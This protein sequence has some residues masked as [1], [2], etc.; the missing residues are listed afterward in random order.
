MIMK[1]EITLFCLIGMLM[2]MAMRTEAQVG[3]NNDN[4]PVDRSAGLDVKFTD[5]GVLIPRLTF[6]QRNA[7]QN[8]AEGLMVYCTNCKRDGTGVIS[9][10]QGGLWMNVTDCLEPDRPAAGIHQVDVAQITWIWEPVPGA[11][12]YKWSTT[13]DFHTASDMGSNTSMSETGLT[14]GITYTRYVWAYNSCGASQVTNMIQPLV[15]IGLSYQGGIIVYLYQPGDTG[16]IAGETHGLIAA[17]V[18]QGPGAAWGCAGTLIGTSAAIGKGQA[19]TA[20]IVNACST[21]GIAARIC[22]TLVLNG[23]SDWFLPSKDE[24]NQLYLHRNVIGDPSDIYWSS[25]EYN[26][27]MAWFQ[28]FNVGYPDYQNKAT[29]LNVRAVRAF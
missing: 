27:A 5:K 24:L 18:D 11:T 15:Y 19:N 1:K 23:Y 9:I 17:A 12:G 25:T 8:P 6:D 16:Y 4:S 14:A 28:I 13:D 26:A 7:I 20:A 3:I 21:G 22:D 2:F 10:F 29:P